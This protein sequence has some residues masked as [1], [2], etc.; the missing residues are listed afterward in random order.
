[1]HKIVNYMFF[2]TCSEPVPKND[3]RKKNGFLLKSEGLKIYLYKKGFRS[4]NL[5]IKNVRRKKKIGKKLQ[6]KNI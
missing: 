4:Y 6:I 3:T 5:I 2:W 1:M